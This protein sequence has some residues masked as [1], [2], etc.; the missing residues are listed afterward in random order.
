VRL[1]LLTILVLSNLSLQSVAY[2][3]EKTAVAG[4]HSPRVEKVANEE[5]NLSTTNVNSPLSVPIS[6]AQGASNPVVTDS[7]M[8]PQGRRKS[9]VELI[10][11]TL[12]DPFGFGKL[13]VDLRGCL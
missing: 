12:S 5:V 4:H 9:I 13:Q 1:S 11:D 3:D 8:P 2:D 7:S 6:S 10:Y